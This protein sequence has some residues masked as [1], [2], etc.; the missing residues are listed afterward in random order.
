MKITD[1]YN[2]SFAETPLGIFTVNG[3]WFYT[4]SQ[5]I[6]QFAPGLLRKISLKELVSRAEIWV[7]STDAI[8][9]LGLVILLLLM[10][11]YMAALFSVIV[12]VGWNLMKSA[13]VSKTTTTALKILSFDPLVL[14]TAVLA[15]SYLGIQEEYTSLGYGLLFFILLRFGW[16]RKGFE[17]MYVRVNEGIGLNDRVMKMVIIREALYHD[18]NIRQ[19][20]QMEDRIRTLMQKRRPAVNKNKNSKR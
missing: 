2:D 20:H 17:L 19:V 10:P 13:F 8:S 11:G 7:R 6:E 1:N 5:E 15:L 9:V 18:V 12:M 4:N 16:L 3:H 14:L